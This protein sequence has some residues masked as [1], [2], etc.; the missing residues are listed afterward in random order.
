MGYIL[1]LAVE[2]DQI[3]ILETAMFNNEEAIEVL[4]HSGTKIDLKDRYWGTPLYVAACFN[5]VSAVK[6]LL[7]NG[8]FLKVRDKFG[9]T[10]LAIALTEN[11]HDF[12]IFKMI[13][14]K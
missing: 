4:V 3:S 5:S 1:Y 8:S 7:R 12:E 6:M 14:I 13:M 10:P 11:E 9:Y 2:F